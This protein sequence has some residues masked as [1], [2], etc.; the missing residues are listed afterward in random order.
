MVYSMA[1]LT[2]NDLVVF[3]P[4]TLATKVLQHAIY[5]IESIDTNYVQ[6]KP[7]NPAIS[8][9]LQKVIGSNIATVKLD[10]IIPYKGSDINGT[11]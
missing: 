3:V 4:N 7:I 5:K 2:T 8:Q 11:T 9:K 10:R 1:V 6:V